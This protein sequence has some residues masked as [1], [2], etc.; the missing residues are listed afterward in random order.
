MTTTEITTHKF[1]EITERRERAIRLTIEGTQV[2]LPLKGIELDEEAGTVAHELLDAKLA[3]AAKGDRMVEMG[4]ADWESAKCL[5]FDVEAHPCDDRT[6]ARRV[7]LFVPKSQMDGTAAPGW[8]IDR[9][10]ANRAM[11]LTGPH[12]FYNGD[13]FIGRVA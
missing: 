9:E 7:R 5:G 3:E 8:I 4:E 13:D 10:I 11:E 2:W 12:T 1:T 6:N